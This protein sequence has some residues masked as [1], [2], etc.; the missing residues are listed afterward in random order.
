MTSK[1]HKPAVMLDRESPPHLFTLIVVTG[2]AAWVMNAFLPSMPGIAAHFDAPYAQVQFMVSG[3]LAANAVLQIIIG[4]LS[5]RFGR[6]QVL[7][8]SLIIFCLA[9]AGCLIA[10][11][12]I[13][14]LA[15]RTLQAVAVAG[16]VLSRAVIGDIAQR[17]QA[18][19]LIGYVTTGMAVLPLL[20]PVIG[21]ILDEAF[22]WQAN[23]QLTLALGLLTLALVWADHGETNLTPTESALAQFR[24]YPE[25]IRSA[26][27]WAY[28]L[29][30]GFASAAFFAFLGAVPFV[31]VE[32]LGMRP[33]GLGL[34]MALVAI[35]YMAGSFIV[36]RWSKRTGGP[37]MIVAGGLMLALCCL[38][39]LALALAGIS[40]PL[41]IFGTFALMGLGNGLTLANAYA[42]MVVRPH[43]AGSASGLGGALVIGI[44][45]AVSALTGA[46]I[47]RETGIWPL[48][49]VMSACTVLSLIATW[50]ALR[51]AARNG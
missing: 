13:S 43:L 7:I 23:F 51:S 14:F 16:I 12:I 33:S 36:G 46:I 8:A 10:P 39:S 50:W 9:T 1:T 18:A 24:A 21:G 49:W 42:G 28:A 44:G 27:F 47:S 35:G 37:A 5:D 26:S 17:D 30:S 25:L 6:R 45:A 41:A 22:G 29:T 15:A 31:A 40:D 11:D 34:Y 38:V 4:P 20:G 48:L 2:L 3:Y 32:L 19:S